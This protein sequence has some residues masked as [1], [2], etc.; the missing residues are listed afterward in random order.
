M[1]MLNLGLFFLDWWGL[2]GAEEEHPQLHESAR[3]TPK[4]QNIKKHKRKEMATKG[5][6]S[7]FRSRLDRNP[8]IQDF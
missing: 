7:N 5:W 2:L 6:I 3:E 8:I 4:A 1:K